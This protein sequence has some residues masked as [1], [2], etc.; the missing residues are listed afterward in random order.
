MYGRAMIRARNAP[1]YKLDVGKPV[2]PG[3]SDGKSASLTDAEKAWYAKRVADK[4]EPM[5]L[6]SLFNWLFGVRS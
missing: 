2:S 5:T 6:S 3:P 4:S 1:G